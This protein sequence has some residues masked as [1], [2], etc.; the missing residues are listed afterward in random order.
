MF[1]ITQLA[2]CRPEMELRIL[3]VDSYVKF[4]QIFN[5]VMC[6]DV[7]SMEMTADS[8]CRW[9]QR[10]Y[11]ADQQLNRLAGLKLCN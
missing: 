7:C 10:I 3:Q 6:S 11:Q 5:T 1:S 2:E 9:M 4:M 8:E